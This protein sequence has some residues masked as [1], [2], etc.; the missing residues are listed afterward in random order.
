[1]DLF[2]IFAFLYFVLII[3]DLI[4]TIRKKD[5]K[6]LFISIPVYLITIALNFMIALGIQ[7]P[8]VNLAL[9]QLISSIFHMQ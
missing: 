4:P 7:L 6:A 3:A 1:M 9:K 8:K 2:L 5:K